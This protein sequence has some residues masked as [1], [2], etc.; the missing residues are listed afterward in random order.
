MNF[1]FHG[2]LFTHSFL[3][4][5]NVKCFISTN[6]GLGLESGRWFLSVA[7][8]LTGAM[9]NS[10]MQGVISGAFI[11]LIVIM[12][13]NLFHI[14]DKKITFFIALAFVAFPSVASIY[15]Y[16]FTSSQYFLSVFLAVAGAYL[17]IRRKWA[18]AILLAFS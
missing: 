9:S 4:H 13:V 17:I 15:T 8:W 10:W 2:F 7:T 12:I 11:G 5:D 1:L 16:M 6:C 14:R 3:N 18:G